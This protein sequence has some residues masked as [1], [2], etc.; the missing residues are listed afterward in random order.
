MGFSEKSHGGD[1][2]RKKRIPRELLGAFKEGHRFTARDFVDDE[3]ARKLLNLALRGNKDAQAVLKYIAQFNNEYYKAVFTKTRSDFFRGKKLRREM[4]DNDN[5]RRRDVLSIGY[6]EL[7]E[8]IAL[9]SPEDALIEMID[10]KR[11]MQKLKK[12]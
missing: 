7:S 2:I 6:I 11:E 3:F 4:Y 10:L 5:A 12:Q 9:E 1:V 8:T